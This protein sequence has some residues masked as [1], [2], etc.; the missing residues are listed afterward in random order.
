MLRQ[1][2]QRQETFSNYQFHNIGV[3]TNSQLRLSNGVANDFQDPGLLGNP[4]VSNQQHAGKFKVPSLR[5]VA[6]T[7]PYMHNGVFQQLSTVLAFYD[8][9]NNPKRALNPETGLPWRPAETPTT[10]NHKLLIAKT[11]DDRKLLALE[12]FLKTLTDK[13]YES[14]LE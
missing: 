12:A 5:N 8:Q 4:Q 3:P 14:Q 13:R 9:F 6:I 2:E 10:V 1:P 7:G 11:L